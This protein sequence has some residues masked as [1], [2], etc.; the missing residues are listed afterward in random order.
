MKVEDRFNQFKEEIDIPD[1]GLVVLVGGNNSGKSTILR[2]IDNSMP[3][4]A[5]VRCNRLFIFPEK[6]LD[7]GSLE[8]NKNYRNNMKSAQSDN[9]EQRIDVLQEFWKLSDADKKKILNYFNR[10]F[11]NKLKWI[12]EDPTSTTSTPLLIMNGHS[13]TKQGTGARAILE[14]LV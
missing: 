8:N 12:Y 11:P 9:V 6:S 4:C 1:Q 14:I 3:D 13:I 2:S 5:F 10:N 7:K